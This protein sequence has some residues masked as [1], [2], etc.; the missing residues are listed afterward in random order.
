MIFNGQKKERD[1]YSENLTEA[2]K[3]FEEALNSIQGLTILSRGD[4]IVDV[5]SSQGFFDT[6]KPVVRLMTPTF[7]RLLEELVHI[8]W[9]PNAFS[10]SGFW[11]YCY[12]Y[13]SPQEAGKSFELKW[14]ST[15]PLGGITLK[16]IGQ[17]T[18]DLRNY[19]PN[20]DDYVLTKNLDST[21]GSYKMTCADL[22]RLIPDRREYNFRVQM[23]GD[24]FPIESFSPYILLKNWHF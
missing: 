10:T 12:E 16:F 4:V 13:G 2:T 9:G 15:Y 21:V 6:L 20:G 22:W 5:M 18:T 8:E 1:F 3:S 14:T 17:T 7:D 24:D 19:T 11:L 23:L